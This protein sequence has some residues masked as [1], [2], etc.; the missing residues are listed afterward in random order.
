MALA[1]RFKDPAFRAE[2]EHRL[3]VNGSP[4]AYM[5]ESFRAGP[6]GLVPYVEIPILRTSLRCIVIGP[7]RPGPTSVG[8]RCYVCSAVIY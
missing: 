8:R 3:V 7:P 2:A 5:L 1:A 6:L 4:F